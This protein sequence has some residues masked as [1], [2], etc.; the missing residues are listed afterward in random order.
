MLKNLFLINLISLDLQGFC[1]QPVEAV[2][3]NV[4]LC[5]CLCIHVPYMSVCSGIGQHWLSWLSGYTV[6]TME[7]IR[8]H[9]P[10]SLTKGFLCH[11][12]NHHNQTYFLF[13]SSPQS[14]PLSSDSSSI[15]ISIPLTV[16]HLQSSLSLFLLLSSAFL[17]IPPLSLSSPL[18]LFPLSASLD[19][20]FFYLQ[21]PS[22]SLSL[23][24]NE[25]TLLLIW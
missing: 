14:P 9:I 8:R 23:S 25:L 5:M 15:S 24:S 20:S 10:A 4:S 13:L 17:T 21:S 12:K 1:L 7:P 2:K 3:Q 6:V 16:S 18:P 19:F 22:S 11:T